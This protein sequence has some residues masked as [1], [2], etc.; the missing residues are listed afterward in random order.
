MNIMHKGFFDEMI[1]IL[2]WFLHVSQPVSQSNHF[3]I[4][5]Q[6][7]QMGIMKICCILSG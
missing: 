7:T 5:F 2:G 4:L 6:H 1:D 3:L